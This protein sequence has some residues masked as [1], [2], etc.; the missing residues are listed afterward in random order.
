MMIRPKER[1]MNKLK[2]LMNHTLFVSLNSHALQDQDDDFC[3]IRYIRTLDEGLWILIG[4]CSLSLFL[5]NEPETEWIWAEGGHHAPFKPVFLVQDRLVCFGYSANF[6]L[7]NN[8]LESKWRP[9]EKKQV[10]YPTNSLIRL[11]T[12]KILVNVWNDRK[13]N[14]ERKEEKKKKK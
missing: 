14:K 1:T 10:I 6:F 11:S 7:Q 3:I 4:I 9:D 8:L 13:V 2:Q 5:H 12:K